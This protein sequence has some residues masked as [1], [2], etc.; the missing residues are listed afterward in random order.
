MDQMR[1]I[2][3]VTGPTATGKT[4]LAIHLARRFSGEI[5]SVDSRQVYRGMDIGTGKDLHAYSCGGS[6]V[7]YH[8]VDIVEP[9][10]EYNLARFVRDAFSAIRDIAD[11]DQLPVLCGG[12]ALYLDALLRGYVLPG[13]ALPRRAPDTPRV[14]QNGHIPSFNPP[15]RLTPLT[16]GLY[17]HRVDVRRRIADRL[18]AR[19]KAGMIEEVLRLHSADG[20]PYSRLEFFG[21]E[22]REIA[23]YLQGRVT[24]EEMRTRLLSRICQFAKRQDGF[25]RK[26]EREGTVI[27]WLSEP[28]VTSQ[29][30]A[31]TK[32]FLAGLPL[33]APRLRMCD[34]FY[35]MSPARF[36]RKD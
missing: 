31:L 27:H 21:L 2:L 24:K 9:T 12:S 34:T 30:E 18:D 33:P 36:T 28:D 25:F 16:L 6:P 22:Y 5:V 11:R 19:L 3:V 1:K 10:E 14:R 15:F 7:P 20:I 26:M 32:S 29:A 17:Y 8:L 13:N 4:A 23:H 35:G